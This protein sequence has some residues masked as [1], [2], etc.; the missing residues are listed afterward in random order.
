MSYIVFAR[1]WRPQNF[2]DV[3]GQEHIT[4]TLKNAIKQ[5]RVAHA[6]LFC[7]PRGIGKTTTARILAKAL[8]CEKGSTPTPCNKCSSCEEITEGRSMDIIEIDGAS[9]RGID[10]IRNL[11]EKI[12]FSPQSGKF[13]VYIIDEVH[14]LTPEAFNALLKTLE[15]PPAH[16][17]FVF[18][19]T[20]AYK[21]IPTIL[22]RCQRF[23]FRRLSSQ[24]IV[25]KLKNIA[26]QEKVKVEE[27]ALFTIVRAASGSMRDAESLL[28]QMATYCKNNITASDTNK[29]LGS[30]EQSTLYDFTKCIIDKDTASAIK[31]INKIM[32]A[33]V[34]PAQ[35]IQNLIEYFRNAMLIKEGKDVIPLLDLTKDEAE[36]ISKQVEPLTTE[37]I[38]Y[39]IYS[40]I[41][42]SNTIRRV[43]SPKITLELLAV[44][45]SQK[46]SIISIGEIMR[47]LSVLE[48]ETGN[49][50]LKKRVESKDYPKSAETP[51]AAAN[52]TDEKPP[53]S[54]NE[55][56]NTDTN[57]DASDDSDGLESGAALYRVREVM[58]Q[59]IKNMKQEKI[60]V[61]SCLAEGR[62]LSFKNN[63]LT[64]GFL[65]KN[66]FH[67]E[68][69]EKAQNKKLIEDHLS[70]LLGA[71]TRI[72]IVTIKDDKGLTAG[73]GSVDDKKEEAPRNPLKKAL[74]DP[75]IKSALDIF[76]GS[77]MKFF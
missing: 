27:S 36:R 7:G 17:K 42:T 4:T 41:N 61:S 74:S 57:A 46:E 12:K 29:V 60:Y 26:K 59:V 64:I 40:L 72:E 77:I 37:D 38:L 21:V 9:N 63:K 62:L 30:I 50:S 14:M 55:L 16:V 75:I 70:K 47:R 5:D 45:L 22:S 31:L 11:K 67:K 66:T 20:A 39:I 52:I 15:E 73:E 54:G 10:E 24:D 8:N 65:K 23:N 19:T 44:K 6:Y 34:D 58:P 49:T 2:D 43:S 56:E 35:F 25:K 48:K 3:I 51:K 18:A 53:L 1:K 32:D 33:G 76:D 71:N 68:N 28:D 69:I 13:K